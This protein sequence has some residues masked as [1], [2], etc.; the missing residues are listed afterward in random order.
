MSEFIDHDHLE[1]VL[2]K[3]IQGPFSMSNG[4]ILLQL[5]SDDV[6][7]MRAAARAYLAMAPRFKEIDVWRVEGAIQ[8]CGR[9]LPI[10]GSYLSRQDADAAGDR[11]AADGALCIAVT[12]PHKQRVPA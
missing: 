8:I 9:W 12:G 7:V 5:D 2:A 4:R 1:R 3:A 10:C 11:N 6:S